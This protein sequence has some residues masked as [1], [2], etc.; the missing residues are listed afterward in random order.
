VPVWP[1]T[2]TTDAAGAREARSARAQAA[3]AAPFERAASRVVPLDWGSA[4]F[5]DEFPRWAD[6]NTLRVEVPVPDLDAERLEAVVERHQGGLEQRRIEVFDAETAERLGPGM[7]ALGYEPG[8]SVLMGWDGGEPPAAPQVEEVPY[9]AV[10]HLRAEWLRGDPW[11]PVLEQALAA[12]RHTF[13]TTR[14]RAFAVVESGLTRAYGL[15]VDL[16]EV[17]LVEDVYTS[18]AVRGRGLGAAVI[19]RL[20]WESR[21]GGHADTVLATPSAGPARALYERLGFTRLGVVH[22]FLRRPR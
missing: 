15:L 21:A 3:R 6:L 19:H 14:T 4:I 2:T 9:R 8:R 17:A 13:A 22:R 1:R 11:A 7:A 20:V 10:E 5:S 16:G 18:P 12:D